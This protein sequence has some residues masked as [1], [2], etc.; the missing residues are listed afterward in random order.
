[1]LYNRSYIVHSLEQMKNKIKPQTSEQIRYVFSHSVSSSCA[2]ISYPY[3][4]RG[5]EV[6]E[7]DVTRGGNNEL[8]EITFSTFGEEAKRVLGVRTIEK[9]TRVE[10]ED[11]IEFDSEKYLKSIFSKGRYQKHNSLYKNTHHRKAK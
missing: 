2:T 5:F 6:L 9:N 1:M 8:K 4:P 3:P 10:K 7:I 11:L